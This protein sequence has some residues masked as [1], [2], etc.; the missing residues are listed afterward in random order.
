[1]IN[2]HFVICYIYN[3]SSDTHFYTGGSWLCGYITIMNNHVEVNKASDKSKPCEYF[4][5]ILML[6]VVCVEILYFFP[7]ETAYYNKLMF[8]EYR[9]NFLLN[10][11]K[12]PLIRELLVDEDNL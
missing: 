1:M 8:L 2:H 10:H 5:F 12:F 11:I 4:L 3:I 6:F 7:V 9:S